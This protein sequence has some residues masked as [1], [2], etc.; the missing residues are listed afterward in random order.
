M[1]DWGD[2]FAAAGYTALAGPG[3]E[4]WESLPGS[5]PGGLGDFG[6]FG[7]LGDLGEFGWSLL[8]ES[9]TELDI[10]D[11]ADAELDTADDLDPVNRPRVRG[12]VVPSADTADADPPTAVVGEVAAADEPALAD[13]WV[14]IDLGIQFAADDGLDVADDQLADAGADDALDDLLDDLPDDLPG[15][16]I[17]G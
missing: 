5:E 1:T 6:D 16:G 12:A 9:D 15:P 7:E 3:G 13:G 11:G 4:A 17:D 14:A 2:V 8:D 10:A